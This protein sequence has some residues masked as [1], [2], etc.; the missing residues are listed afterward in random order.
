[1]KPLF[2]YTTTMN[3][4]DEKKSGGLLQDLLTNENL[5]YNLPSSATV[6]VEKSQKQFFADRVEYKDTDDRIVFT[7]NSGSDFID[8]QNSYLAFNLAVT[9]DQDGTKLVGFG[10]QGSAC[11]LI[12]EIA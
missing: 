2:H 11:N 5:T 8:G 6:V 12:Q 10:D 3:T 1:M 7:L 9:S 4:S